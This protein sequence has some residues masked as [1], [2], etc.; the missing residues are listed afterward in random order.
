MFLAISKWPH[1]LSPCQEHGLMFISYFLDICCRGLVEFFEV[2]L[3]N[4][5]GFPVTLTCPHWASRNSSTTVHI[6]LTSPAS[7]GG[8]R[9]GRLW[10]SASACLFSTFVAVVCPVT[11]AFQ[12]NLRAVPFFKNVFSSSLVRIEQC[13]PGSFHARLQIRSLLLTFD[14]FLIIYD[15]C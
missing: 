15:I 2:K 5:W 12:R 6:F 1:F 3:T 14:A 10:F 4:M 8:F 7:H 9:A 13:F 11:F